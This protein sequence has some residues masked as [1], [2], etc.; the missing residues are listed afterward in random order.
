MVRHFARAGV[1]Y[2]TADGGVDDVTRGISYGK[3]KHDE[4]TAQRYHQPSDEYDARTWNL[5]GGLQDI[6]V[7]YAIGRRLAYSREWPQW[8]AGSEFKAIREKTAADRK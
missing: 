3:Q 5:D 2:L 7:V 1:P 6:E 4:Y 8:K